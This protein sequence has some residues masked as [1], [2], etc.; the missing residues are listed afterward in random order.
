[1]ATRRRHRKRALERR[2][3]QAL[4][5]NFLKFQVEVEKRKLFQGGTLFGKGN[6]LLVEKS[7]D[8]KRKTYKITK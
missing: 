4:Q 8:L 1:M 5:M 2:E 7:N 6:I 3:N